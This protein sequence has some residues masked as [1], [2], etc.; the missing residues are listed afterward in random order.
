MNAVGNKRQCIDRLHHNRDEPRRAKQ[1]QRGIRHQ[2]CADRFC[3]D[4]HQ[5]PAQHQT[6][7]PAAAQRSDA[8]HLADP[9]GTFE[10]TDEALCGDGKRV[11]AERRK[12]PNLTNRL[13]RCTA[14]SA[15]LGGKA[16]RQ[17][18]EEG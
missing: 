13:M 9:V 14:F 3:G 18:Q 16:C 11:K 1:R 6:D 8:L 2:P 15:D 17:Q 5:Y 7:A 10:I 4:Q 12:Q